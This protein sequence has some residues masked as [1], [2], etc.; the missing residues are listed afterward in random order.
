MCV[1]IFPL[2][3]VSLYLV[4]VPSYYHHLLLIPFK[5]WLDIYMKQSR[6]HMKMSKSGIYELICKRMFHF[7]LMN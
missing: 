4:L 7:V 5:R 2:T 3:F 6:K 1:T